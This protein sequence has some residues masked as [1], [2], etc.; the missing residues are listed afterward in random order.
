MKFPADDSNYA[1]NNDSVPE[2][3][4]AVKPES[5]IPAPADQFDQGHSSM[6][7]PADDSNDTSKN[8]SVPEQPTAA[9]PESSSPA[10]AD[11]FDPMNLGISTDYAAAIN[12]KPS[13]KPFELRKPNDQEYF[14]SSPRKDHH[15]VVGSIADKQD[16]G[17]IYLV[18]PT[19]LD[20]VKFAFPRAVRAVELVLAQSMMGVSIVWPVPLAEDRGGKW[21]SSQRVVCEES[22]KKWTNLVSGQGQYDSE[23][24]NNPRVVDWDAFPPFRDVLR[25]AASERLIDSLDH[26]L[27]KKLRGIIE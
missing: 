7:F 1:G 24:I 16:M 10:P 11:P 15:L 5:S 14:R 23:P 9:K 22:K 2:Q 26:P 25:Q 19:L 17:K 6:K 18:T 3:P 21:N 12:V 20:A 4:E 13:A 27:L 8:D